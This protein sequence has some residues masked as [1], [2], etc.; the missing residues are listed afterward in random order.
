MYGTFVWARRA[1]NR[2]KWPFPA[3][4]GGE[5]EADGLADE[6]ELET[7]EGEDAE[8]ADLYYSPELGNVAFASAHDGWAFRLNV[9]ALPGRLSGL[10]VP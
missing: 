6:V 8:D 4:A 10:S 7:A 1:L 5:D 2:R 9:R 3:R